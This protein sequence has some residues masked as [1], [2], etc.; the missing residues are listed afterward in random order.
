MSIVQN[1]SAPS[2]MHL[3]W[4]LYST[5]EHLLLAVLNIILQKIEVTSDLYFQGYK[6]SG[7][8][9]A[10]QGPLQNTIVDFWRMIWESRCGCI[11]MLCELEERGRVEL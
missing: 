8:Y 1:I 6:H 9:V 5:L 10:T 11:V 7:A 4:Y 2:P 3:V